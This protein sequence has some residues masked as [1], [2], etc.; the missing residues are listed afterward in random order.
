MPT[1][2]LIHGGFHGGWCWDKVRRGLQQEGWAVYAP[3]LTGVG[4]RAHLASPHITLRTHVQDV[5]SLIESENLTDVVLCGHSAAGMVITGVADTIAE[6]LHTL[7]Y[8]DAA[9]PK[10]GESMFDIIGQD[11]PMTIAFKRKAAEHGQGWFVPSG[12][13][14]AADFGVTDPADA[15]WVEQHLTGHPISALADPLRLANESS[16]V[17]NKVYVQCTKRAH[18]PHDDRA[19]T[20][21]SDRP[22]WTFHR[23]SSAHDVMITE[24]DRVLELFTSIAASQ[25]RRASG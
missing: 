19:L 25:P 18:R 10:D 17:P 2:V 16:R 5:V 6:R 13:F 9:I 3:S 7:V 1:A 21:A 14:S 11:D 12:Y 23:W 4:D 22:G 8:L 24:P 20:F 15:T